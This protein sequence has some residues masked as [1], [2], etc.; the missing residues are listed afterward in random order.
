MLGTGLVAIDFTKRVGNVQNAYK[1]KGDWEKELFVESS[2]FAL[3]AV[4]G[5]L[6]VK[7]GAR[8]LMFLTVATPMGWVG[9]IVV[10]AGV[11]MAANYLTKE[12]SG[13]VYDNV[14][15]WLRAL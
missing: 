4:A 7:V 8:A 14:M 5:G 11:S 9:L 3:T 1:A 10:G 2:S 6:A 15:E 13:D 12:K